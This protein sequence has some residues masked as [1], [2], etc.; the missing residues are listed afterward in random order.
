MP[1]CGPGRCA[2]ARAFPRWSR[3]PIAERARLLLKIAEQIDANLDKLALAES[4]DGGKP[5]HRARTA[6]IPRARRT[7][8]FFA[9]A[10]EQFHS[11]A[12]RTDQLALNYTLRQP[13]AS[14]VC[15]RRG[16]CRC[17][18][19]TWKIAPR[20][21]DRQYRRGQALELTPTAAH[22]LTEI[23]QESACLRAL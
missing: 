22:L 18:F 21:G 7:S 2:A 16:T 14:P 10:I 15:S 11:E 17:I 23:C 20:A 9:S 8:A 5:L 13:R 1:G 4:T 3:A 19:S 6:E 12:Y